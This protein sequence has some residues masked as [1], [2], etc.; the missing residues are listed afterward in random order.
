MA[1]FDSQYPVQIAPEMNDKILIT[2]ER[3]G[4]IMA[5]PLG[6]VIG[7]IKESRYH[8]DSELSETSTNPV[9]NKTITLAIENSI[10]LPMSP[11]DIDA[12]CI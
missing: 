11:S 10:P 8:V 3:D 7:L 2:S 1:K 4:K 5:L 9:Q 6:T 12:A